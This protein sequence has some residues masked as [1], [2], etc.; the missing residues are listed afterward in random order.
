[1]SVMRRNAV[2]KTVLIRL[3][4][5]YRG[6]RGIRDNS[7]F[8]GLS[9]WKNRPAILKRVEDEELS[10]LH[11]EIE[12]PMGYLGRK[13]EEEIRVWSSGKSSALEINI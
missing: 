8:I 13:G 12:M 1:M 6:K 2:F 7:R 10:F 5:S 9:N 3:D 11:V 4:S